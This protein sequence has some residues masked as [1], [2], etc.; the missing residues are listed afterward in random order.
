MTKE[1][2]AQVSFAV[3]SFEDI[4]KNHWDSVFRNSST[5]NLYYD[6]TL[7]KSAM[8]AWPDCKPDGVATGYDRNNHLVFLQPFREKRS[9]LGRT[10][11]LLRIPTADRIEPLIAAEN[12]EMALADFANFLRKTLKPDLLIA[13]SLTQKFCSS[14]CENF[15]TVSKKVDN[16]GR[17]TILYLP[18]TLEEFVAHYKSNFRCQLRHKVKKGLSAG[19]SFRQIN[20][21]N[22]PNNYDLSQ[23]LE[24]LTRLH[25]KRFD[26]LG[27]DSFFVRPDYQ[28]FHKYLCRNY[29]DPAFMLTFTESLHDSRVIG[30]MYRIQTPFIYVYLMIGFD[31]DFAPMSIGN[32]MI[33]QTIRQLFTDRVKAFDFKVGDEPYK[34][35]WTKSEFTKYNVSI[36]FSQRGK[37]LSWPEQGR[38]FGDRLKRVPGKIRIHKPCR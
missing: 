30:S 7:I 21:R 22:L 20:S 23:A 3:R 36:H 4:E 28:K 34:K 8:A 9:A 16:A 29:E 17:G 35:Q 13:K 11:E 10:I 31:P 38:E 6:Y 37:L 2:T 19:L 14:L 27:K 26:S 12:R 33:Y 15:S 25:A 18:D 32:L 1:Q 5:N 24:N